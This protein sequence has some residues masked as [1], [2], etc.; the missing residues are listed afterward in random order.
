MDHVMPKSRGGEKEWT[1]I[2]ACCKGCNNKKGDRTP[3]EAK[4]PL[5]SSPRIPRWSIHVLLRDREIPEEW[6][7]FL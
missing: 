3:A 5:I 6:Q 4:M 2:V 7:Q 1:N